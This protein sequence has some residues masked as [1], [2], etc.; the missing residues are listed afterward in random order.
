MR[1]CVL[2]GIDRQDLLD[3]ALKGRRLGVVT[4]GGA[5]NKQLKPTLDVLFERYQVV[6]LFNTIY[7]VRAD[8]TYGERVMEYTDQK[9]GLSVTSIF[10]A[11]RIA[12]TAQM[13]EDIDDIV[14]DI[15]E[16]G[17][18]FFEYLHCLAA[19]MRA[20]AG[21]GK[22]VVV[23][24][25]IA[26][27]GGDIVEGTVCPCTMHT[28][29]GDFELPSRTAL[30][31]GEFAQYVNGEFAIGCDLLVIPVSGWKRRMYYD[32]TDVPWL[33]PSPS[34]NSV[35]ANLLYAGYCIFEGI[36]TISEGR[37]TSKP[38][39]LVGA[40]FMD[41][42]ALKAALDKRALPGVY[43]AAVYFKPT[44]SKFSG[45]VCSGVQTVIADRNAFR[46]FLTAL[47][48]LEVIRDM[49]P[50]QI[51]YAD[52]TAGHEVV[53]LPSAPQFTR[54]I[55]KILATD[56]FSTGAKTAQELVDMYAPARERYIARKQKYHLYD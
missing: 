45:E 10:N 53:E 3:A 25:R 19:I 13:L 1:A 8:F 31:M 52:C 35:D 34:L 44:A 28:I 14:F 20:C 40:P 48:M 27:L 38:F 29:V 42:E 55:D 39:E 12:P 24:D 2:S 6:K 41:G 54:Y 22:R 17:T 32:E 9:T 33:L 16:A 23:L 21:A 4:S 30:T 15:R 5:V 46:P 18:R 47:T 7:G 51:Q 43:F 56:V 37:G 11:Q 50:N 49:Y 36:N 26:P